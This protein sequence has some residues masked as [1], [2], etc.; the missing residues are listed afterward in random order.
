[1][2]VQMIELQ[3]LP[4]TAPSRALGQCSAERSRVA[5]EKRVVGKDGGREGAHDEQMGLDS[6]GMTSAFTWCQVGFCPGTER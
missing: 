3:Q 5:R 4:P 2:T 6:Q 1:M